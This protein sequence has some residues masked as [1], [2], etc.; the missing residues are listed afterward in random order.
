MESIQLQ[1]TEE[2]KTCSSHG[3]EQAFECL[4]NVLFARMRGDL[5]SSANDLLINNRFPANTAYKQE[6]LF[7]V[8]EQY[9]LNDQEKLILL[10]S[11]SSSYIPGFLNALT[12]IPAEGKPVPKLFAMSR[13]SINENF[14][15]T[16]ETGLVM[17]AG[18]NIPNRHCSMQLFVNQATL[19]R[20]HLVRVVQ[21]GTQDPFTSL[22]LM[23]DEKL[24]QLLVT[25]EKEDPHFSG[26]FPATLLETD[27]T[28]D[29]LV[30]TYDTYQQI[31][32]VKEWVEFEKIQKAGKPG[33]HK[34][35]LGCKCL[36]HGPPGTGKSLTAS[37]LG[38]Y[39]GKKVY[40]IDLSAVVSKYIGE[41]EKN[42]SYIFDQAQHGNW[43]L[44]FDEADALFGK[45]GN[46]NNAHDRY[47]NQEV[48]YLL[49]RFE[50]Y[51]GLTILASNLIDNIDRAFYRRFHSIVQ[52]TNPGAD[53][54]AILWSN[55]LP[56]G[57]QL[58]DGVDVDEIAQSIDINGAG[59]YNVMRRAY[60]KAV[61]RKETIIMGQ[62]L[63]ESVR[64]EKRKEGKII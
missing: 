49:Q 44:F 28:W 54:R 34:F 61:L 20:N 25:G 33:N 63:L 16:V 35:K 19:L 11:L 46:T 56:G 45:R 13:S 41:T 43:I 58:E 29:E 1:P 39:T 7:Q 17:L 57:Y 2:T 62:D 8:F 55:Y 36:F 50:A 18:D 9:K 42:L 3:M 22:R 26:S 48:S 47:A 24:L 10:L 60:M 6:A 59:I 12:L 30:L 27:F 64:M 53:E 52:F 31:K 38:K 40:R 14:I 21:A 5:H 32:E 15:P 23:P 4:K 37:L 51:E